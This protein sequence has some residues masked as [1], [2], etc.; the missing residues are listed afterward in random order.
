MNK[1]EKAAYK[2]KW[3]EEHPGQVAASGKKWR[4]EH[5]EQI[6]ASGKKYRVEH[7]EQKAANDCEHSN[8][9][10]KFYEQTLVYNTTGLRGERTKRRV[11]DANHWRPYKKIIAS[12]SQIHHA[13][14]PNS[15]E[16]TGVALVEKDQHMHGIIDVIQ[17][18]DGEITVFTEKEIRERGEEA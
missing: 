14:C 3:Q 17:I 8:K 2:K 4:I 7:P 6:A 5:K 18:L 10:G 9:G 13:W 11:K 1:E 16:C 12:D 15:A